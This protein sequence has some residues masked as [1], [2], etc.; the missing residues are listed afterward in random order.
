MTCSG[1]F[2]LTE[3]SFA[4]PFFGWSFSETGVLAQRTAIPPEGEG[5]GSENRQRVQ[6][7]CWWKAGDEAVAF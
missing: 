7:V 5:S 6:I 2:S 3:A 1:C 4:T